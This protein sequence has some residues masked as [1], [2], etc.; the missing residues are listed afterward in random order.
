[1]GRNC[2]KASQ[3]R[4]LFSPQAVRITSAVKTFV[5]CS[6]HHPDIRQMVNK[7]SQLLPQRRV[8]LDQSPLSSIQR[9]SRRLGQVDDPARN[10]DQPDV[11]QERADLKYL[12]LF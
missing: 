10:T 8:L 5:V 6:D 11:M 7:T 4:D 2:Q 1:M 12:P 3:P 9:R